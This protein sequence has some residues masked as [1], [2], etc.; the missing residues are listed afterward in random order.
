MYARNPQR[1][2]SVIELLLV[3]AIIGI[4]AAIAVPSLMGA[5]AAAQEAAALSCLRVISGIQS[6]LKVTTGRY[7]RMS[8]VNA[9]H[10]GDL[11]VMA[12]PTLKRQAYTFQTIP[13]AP[14]DV[15]LTNS[16]RVAATGV[17]PDGVTP[18]IF[19]VDE[20]GVISQLSP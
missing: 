3:V 11:G 15:Q 13:T 20:S 17:G 14:T 19:M 12:G 8:E 10:N 4:I 18:F 5:R 7:G 9:F 6:N 2:F 16:Y 1:G